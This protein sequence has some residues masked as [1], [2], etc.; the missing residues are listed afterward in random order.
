VIAQA[1]EIG[2]AGA[3]DAAV[4]AGDEGIWHDV[5]PGAPRREGRGGLQAE[6]K[7]G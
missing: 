7:S 1:S 6:A 5:T 4:G 2:G 3:A